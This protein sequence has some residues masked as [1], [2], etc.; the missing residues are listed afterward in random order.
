[1]RPNLIGNPYV[2][3]RSTGEWFNPN[4]FALPAGQA[5]SASL[6][7]TAPL[8]SG[9]VARNLLYG[10]GYTDEDVSLFKVLSLPREMK[11]Q[12]RV[13]A[14]NVLNTSRFGQPD[15]DFA[16]LGSASKPGTFGMITG[17]SGANQR[18]MQFAGRL[19]F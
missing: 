14:F 17:G 18:V 15:A 7:S 16:H 3:H 6:G 5:S 10:P 19:T 13:E 2:S 11:F 4:A 8:V 9:N 1:L 12:I